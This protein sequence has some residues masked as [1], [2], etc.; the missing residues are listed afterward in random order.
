MLTKKWVDYHHSSGTSGS[1]TNDRS[2]QKRFDL[3]PG[4]YIILPCAFSPGDEGDFLLRIFTEG[5][6]EAK[7]P[8]PE[9]QAAEVSRRAG[10]MLVRFRSA[11]G[12]AVLREVTVATS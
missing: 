9:G 7:K 6:S 8:T 11:C 12:L 3:E 1:F 2:V 5:Y 10:V 4:R